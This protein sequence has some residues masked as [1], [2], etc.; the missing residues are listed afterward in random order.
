M[1]LHEVGETVCGIETDSCCW[2]RRDRCYTC[3]SYLQMHHHSVNKNTVI[4]H[5]EI[6]NNNKQPTKM[7]SLYIMY[8]FRIG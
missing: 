8:M 2:K 3:I 1:V 7:M 6:N 4:T 5:T